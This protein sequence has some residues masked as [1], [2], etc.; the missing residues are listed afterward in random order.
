MAAPAAVTAGA[1][2]ATPYIAKAA[3]WLTKNMLLP[4]IGYSIGD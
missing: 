4:G 2:V 3:P 1:A